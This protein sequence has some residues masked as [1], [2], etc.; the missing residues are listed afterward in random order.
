M[1]EISTT[2][3]IVMNT[4]IGRVTMKPEVVDILS[5]E[6]VLEKSAEVLSGLFSR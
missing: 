2:M 1:V 6:H 5:L 3:K 4:A